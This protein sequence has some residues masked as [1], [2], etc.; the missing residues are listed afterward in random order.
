MAKLNMYQ[1]ITFVQQA[2][3]DAINVS[4]YRGYR[5]DEKL[6]R[7]LLGSM[8]G[9]KDREKLVYM[10]KVWDGSTEISANDIH[11]VARGY[12]K[13]M[14]NGEAF[15]ELDAWNFEF[16][17]KWWREYY[18]EPKC[19]DFAP[20]PI[21]NPNGCDGNPGDAELVKTILA[22]IHKTANPQLIV[23]YLEYWS[24]DVW[25]I[26]EY[27]NLSHEEFEQMFKIRDV[28]RAQD[29]HRSYAFYLTHLLNIKMANV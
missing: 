27:F 29:M 25:K 8:D 24:R 20:R 17:M 22:I 26:G 16:I 28:E 18:S 13:D 1:V 9:R 14:I 2:R 19:G 6:E 7:M 5:L 15:T 21:P 12:Y 11:S 3:F 10:I 23:E 4:P